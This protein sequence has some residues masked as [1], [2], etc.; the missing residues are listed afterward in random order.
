M[1]DK[2]PVTISPSHK[3]STEDRPHAAAGDEGSNNAASNGFWIHDDVGPKYY[4]AP[5]DASGLN[6]D[7]GDQ[8][9][10]IYAMLR[11]YPGL[12]ASRMHVALEKGVVV[13]GG[14]AVS[15]IEGQLAA[16]AVQTVAGPVQILN[17]LVI[18][19]ALQK[20]K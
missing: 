6:V 20:N 14:I 9:A 12:D 19:G 4:V 17:R 7:E 5:P 1:P 3:V 11:T 10:H 13:L 15:D 8:V 18:D 2:P 16:R